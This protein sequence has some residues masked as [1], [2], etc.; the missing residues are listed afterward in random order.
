MVQT[1]RVLIR[2]GFQAILTAL[3]AVALT[4][5]IIRL[6]GD[7]V[8]L[9]LPPEASEARVS[10]M[11]EFLGFDRPMSVQFIDYLKGVMRGDLGKSLYFKQ[12][13]LE[14]FID[15]LPATILLAAIAIV[16]A[17][18]IGVSL[19]AMAA[20]RKNGPVDYAVNAI[21]LAGQSMPVFWIGI[22]LI[23]AFS[24]RWH[25]FPSSGNERWL[26]IVLPAISLAAY[27]VAPI[28][29]TVR[30]SLL[31]ALSENYIISARAQ[32]FSETQIIFRHALKN[33][34]LPVVTVIGLEFGSLLGGAVVTETV[35][36][37]PGVGR[38]VMTGV[39]NRDFPLVQTS[40]LMISLVYI[41]VNFVTDLLYLYI[42]PRI[43]I[44]S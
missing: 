1:R 12:P 21:V 43:R 37:W 32:G 42:D 38:L 41:L 29:R 33:A 13:A 40:V 8:R 20:C 4:F 14:L 26:S 6:S 16:L 25:V 5:F 39:L 28:A 15:R 7:P 44:D 24:L 3:S 30:S 10:E 17:V 9:M 34:M 36:S 18:V 19:G 11:R 2:N 23:F 27:P 31:N 35:F 22:M